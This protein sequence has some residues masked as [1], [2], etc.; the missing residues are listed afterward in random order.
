MLILITFILYFLKVLAL[1]YSPNEDAAHIY[2]YEPQIRKL[3]SSNEN[4]KKTAK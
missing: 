3:H 2:P 1:P 4:I